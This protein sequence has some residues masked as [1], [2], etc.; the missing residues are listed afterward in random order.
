MDGAVEWMDPLTVDCDVRRSDGAGR[1]CGD[2]NRLRDGDDSSDARENRPSDPAG[3]DFPLLKDRT[4]SDKVW[5][6]MGFSDT[7][8]QREK[9]RHS[10]FE[11]FAISLAWLPVLQYSVEGRSSVSPTRGLAS[12]SRP[13]RHAVRS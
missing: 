4:S 13:K 11:P 6:K 8:L 7:S 9:N 2:A 3:L 12:R 5:M 1:S 10:L